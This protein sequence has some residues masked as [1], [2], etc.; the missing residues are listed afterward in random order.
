MKKTILPFFIVLLAF[1]GLVFAMDTEVRLKYGTAAGAQRIEFVNA[2]GHGASDNGTNT[3]VEVILSPQRDSIARFILT[4]GVFQRKHTGNIADLS[5]PTKADYSVTGISIA[6][7]VRAKISDSWNFEGKFEIGGSTSGKLTLNSPG[8]YWNG[9]RG[10]N[11]GSLSAIFGLYY[12]LFSSNSRVG[13]ELGMQAFS[14]DFEILSNGVGWTNGRVSGR[15]GTAN[16]VYGYQ[17]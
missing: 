2:I 16:I 1:P 11:Y 6:P 15:S 4:I 9:M 13:L 8:V 17:F 5:F 10:G 14:G 12:S 3:Q 7:G